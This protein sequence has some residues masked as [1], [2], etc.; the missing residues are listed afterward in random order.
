MSVFLLRSF[1]HVTY[2]LQVTSVES[3]FCLYHALAMLSSQLRTE[4]THHVLCP[5]GTLRLR[6]GACLNPTQHLAPDKDGNVSRQG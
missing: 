4:S 3:T 6:V 1:L 5:I 2:I